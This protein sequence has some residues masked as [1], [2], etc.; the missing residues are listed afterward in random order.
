MGCGGAERVRGVSVLG[1]LL[2]GDQRAKEEEKKKRRRKEEEEKKKRKRRK[3]KPEKRKKKTYHDVLVG[4]G[5]VRLVLEVHGQQVP[6]QPLVRLVVDAVQDQV[7]QV[8]ARQQGRRQVDVLGHGQV[9]VVAAADGVGR[10]QDAGAGV[11]RGDD[12]GLGDGD[13]LLLH[14]LVQDGAR[15]L[16]HLVELV[17][18]ADAAVGQDQGA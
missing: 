13:G 9:R 11:E 17:D 4:L 2:G 6:G 1:Q 14:D 8:E 12:A 18:A 5:R 3:R 10:G 16:G 15:G 7:D